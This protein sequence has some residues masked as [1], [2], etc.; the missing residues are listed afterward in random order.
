MRDL[1]RAAA[2][3]VAIVLATAAPALAEEKKMTGTITKLDVAADAKSAV[4]VLKDSTTAALVPIKIVDTA[5]LQKLERSVIAVGDEIKCK[6]VK[7]GAGNV[8][9]TF[10]KAAGCS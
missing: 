9:V 8:A 7:K 1:V 6:Y 2:L 5:T 3:A 10:K 4:A